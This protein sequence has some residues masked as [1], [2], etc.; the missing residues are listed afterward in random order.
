[1][2]TVTVFLILL[3]IGGAGDGNRTRAG[4]ALTTKNSGYT[5]YFFKSIKLL[6]SNK[7]I[8]I[9]GTSVPAIEWFS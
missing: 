1:M 5:L 6:I 2:V 8:K 7:M 3:F 4:L 9:A